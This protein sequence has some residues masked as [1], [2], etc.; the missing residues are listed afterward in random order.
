MAENVRHLLPK[1]ERLHVKKDIAALFEKGK[2]RT[3][4]N[5]RYCLREDNGLTFNRIM[6]SVPKRMFK[7]AVKR[8]L[9]R[10]RIRESYRLQKELLPDNAGTDILFIYNS[11]EISA[12]HEIFSTVGQI[13]KDI[14]NEARKG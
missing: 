1:D 6:I 12:W 11:K 4:R 5:I 10:R 13:M 7:R 8:N 2:F 3:C 9:I 14:C